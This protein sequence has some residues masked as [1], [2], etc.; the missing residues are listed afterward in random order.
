MPTAY[1]RNPHEFGNGFKNMI[2]QKGPAAPAAALMAP[3]GGIVSN[4][5]DWGWH[6]YGDYNT[7]SRPVA[8]TVQPVSTLAAD[9]APYMK[10][11]HLW[12]PTSNG[13]QTMN[14]AS[15]PAEGPPLG[16][17]AGPSPT[18]MPTVDSPVNWHGADGATSAATPIVPAEPV[19]TANFSAPEPPPGPVN[20]RL[21]LQVRQRVSEVCAGK[22]LNLAV[23]PLSPIRLRVG[24]TVKTHADAE[25]LTSQLAALPELRPYKVDFEMQIGE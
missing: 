12:H 25:W 8:S 23:E 11:A 14:L 24:M 9:M 21:P 20:S 5:P 4:H 3:P 16:A 6:G 1:E 22:A 13:F 7:H 2:N 18:L 10:Y 19:R 17:S 15:I